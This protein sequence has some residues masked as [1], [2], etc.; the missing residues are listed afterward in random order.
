MKS[1]LFPLLASALAASFLIA[2][3]A[4]FAQD[5]EAPPP[6]NADEFKKRMK[7]EAKEAKAAVQ[8]MLKVFK[9]LE[10]EWT[11]TEKVEHSEETL[12]PLDKEWKDEWKGFFSMEGTYFEMN[13]KTQGEDPTEYRW[14]CTWDESEETYKAWYFGVNGQTLYIGELSEDGK[15]VIWTTESEENNSSTKFTMI[16]DGDRVKCNGKDLLNGRIWSRQT[17]SYTR[18]KV[19]I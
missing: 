17:S 4:A 18:K 10:G 1:R 15:H 9:P 7:E 16:A 11:G 5:E 3:P 8:K 2:A 6:F 19:A 13:G 12:K 14:I